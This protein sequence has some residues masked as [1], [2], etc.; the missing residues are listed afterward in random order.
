[1][2][3]VQWILSVLLAGLAQCLEYETLWGPK[4]PH[5]KCYDTVGYHPC[6]VAHA[7]SRWHFDMQ[8]K[9]CLKSQFCAEDNNNFHTKTECE[10]ACPAYSFCLFDKVA[11]PCTNTT[12]HSQWYFD[13]RTHRCKKS[14]QCVT[15]GNAFVTRSECVSKCRAVDVCDAPRPAELCDSGQRTV[16]YYDPQQGVCR[17][18]INCHHRGNNFPT[19]KECER[20]C[21][22]RVAP[23]PA[24]SQV[25]YTFPPTYGCGR[26][27]ERWV[28]NLGLQEV[29]A[30]VRLSKVRQQLHSEEQLRK[31][32]P[33]RVLLPFP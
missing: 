32:L 26:L 16:W 6:R 1:M 18:D 10:Y 2:Q 20:I 23:V 24:P 25:C 15:G 7:G 19:H 14:H 4:N 33:V 27:V 12:G 21:V 17:K 3:P 29:R 30:D 5:T 11:V 28:Y 22:R 9:S 8:T 31:K 13:S